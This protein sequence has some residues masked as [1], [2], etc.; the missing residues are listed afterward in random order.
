MTTALKTSLMIKCR[1]VH[2]GIV[3]VLGSMQ[4]QSHSRHP[5]GIT[6]TSQLISWTLSKMQGRVR[7]EHHRCLHTCLDRHSQV[8]GSVSDIL[9]AA[10]ARH[11]DERLTCASGF[12]AKS[13]GHSAPPGVH[14]GQ[15]NCLLSGSRS[16]RRGCSA[17]QSGPQ[18]SCCAKVAAPAGLCWITCAAAHSASSMPR[19]ESDT[20]QPAAAAASGLPKPSA[21]CY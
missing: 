18:R 7:L 12:A 14:L 17:L 21:Y 11:A 20:P 3:K 4:R 8:E 1:D 6:A 13:A 2:M 5:D 15:N 9:Q 19:P 10:P 16:R